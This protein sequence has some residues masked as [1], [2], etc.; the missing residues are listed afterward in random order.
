MS[1]PSES[2]PK[3]FSP[4]FI[5]CICGS[6]NSY[7]DCCGSVFGAVERD[8]GRV[9][10]A[11][12]GGACIGGLRIYATLGRKLGDGRGQPGEYAVVF[13]L[14]NPGDAPV[15]PGIVQI[16]PRGDSHIVIGPGKVVRVTS[17]D[18]EQ[19]NL[20]FIG[21]VNEAGRL[22]R[23]ELARLTAAT[24][25]DAARRAEFAF[26]RLLDRWALEYDV[27]ISIMQVNVIERA[28]LNCQVGTTMPFPDVRLDAANQGSRSVE[29]AN[30][31]ALYREGLV[32]SSVLYEFLCLFK[33][34]E[35]LRKLK[36]SGASMQTP[37]ERIPDDAA[38]F[39]EWVEFAYHRGACDSMSTSL[40]FVPEVRGKKVNTVIETLRP[41]RV[42]I[43][44][45]LS[46]DGDALDSVFTLEGKTRYWLPI[47]RCIAR[48]RMKQTFP[49][50]FG[51]MSQVTYVAPR[52]SAARDNSNG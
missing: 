25:Y 34:V 10:I 39:V 7:D 48:R 35:A 44:H 18:P 2:F 13:I 19:Q 36:P 31:S 9:E 1:A 32:S 51:G 37:G 22:A 33:I 50:E 20:E 38:Q 42:A 52:P 46:L 47:L 29:F 30:L 11:L 3:D 45:A 8:Y 49:A 14:S 43:A 17:S 23:M 26:A 41:L 12:F 5:A 16:A 40:L 15:A 28:T 24:C 6:S 27:G 21:R 4:G